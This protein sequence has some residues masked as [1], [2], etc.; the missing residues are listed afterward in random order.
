MPT[1]RQ[2]DRQLD[3][4]RYGLAL[5]F[6]LTLYAAIVV[7][8]TVQAFRQADAGNEWRVYAIGLA[9]VLLGGA[10]GFYHYQPLWGILCGGLVGGLLAFFGHRLLDA[11]RQV[12]MTWLMR[13]WLITALLA[14]LTAAMLWRSKDALRLPFRK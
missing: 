14:A 13:H 7:G 11:D 10:I 5:M 2:T 6:T 8:F 3:R 12:F 4:N 9:G 1:P